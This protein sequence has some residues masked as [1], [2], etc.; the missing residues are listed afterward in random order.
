M[1][2][3]LDPELQPLVRRVQQWDEL[4]AGAFLSAAKRAR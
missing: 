2:L 4:D 3:S 1:S